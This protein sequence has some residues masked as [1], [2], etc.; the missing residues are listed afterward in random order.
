MLVLMV[1]AAVACLLSLAAGLAARR[2]LAGSLV[3]ASPVPGYPVPGRCPGQPPGLPRRWAALARAL[4]RP[5]GWVITLAGWLMLWDTVLALAAPWPLMLVVDYGLTGRPYPSWLAGAGRLSP[6]VL[7]VAAAA[8]GLA[9]LALGAVA[10][11]LVT[12]LTGVTGERVTARLRGGLIAHLLRI[13][14]GDAARYP[15]GELLNRVSADTLRVCDTVMAIADTLLPDS[16]LLAGM[17][18]ITAVLDWRLTLVVLGVVP[19]YVVLA[20]RRNRALGGAQ[21]QARQRSGELSALAADLLARIPAVHVFGRADSEATDYHRVSTGAAAAEVAA[22][23]A[24]ARFGPAADLLPGLGMAGALVAG[25]I[26]VSAGRLT[27][28]GLLVFLA[29]LSSLTSP[30]R[31][32]AQLSTTLTRGSVSRDRI[33]E[34]LAHPVLEPVAEVPSGDAGP[35]REAG[36][37]PAAVPGREPAPPLGHRAGPA[38]RLATA[39]GPAQV[40]CTERTAHRP[41][42]PGDPAG[43]RDP[44]VVRLTHPGLL[45]HAGLPARPRPAAHPDLLARHLLLARGPH[46]PGAARPALAAQTA[47]ELSIPGAADPGRPGPPPADQARPGAPAVVPGCQGAVTAAGAA[48]QLELVSFAHHPGRLVLDAASLQVRAGEFVCLAGPSGGGKSTL[49]SLLVRLAEPDCGQITIGGADISR[50]PLPRL[51]DLVT[52]VPQDPW[53]HT[54]TIAANIAYGRPGA[55]RGQVLDAARR[56][57]VAAFAAG[58]PAGY[59]TVVGE[60]GRQLSG[61]QQRRVAIARALL[62]A[63]PVLLLD[64]PTAGLDPPTEECLV[65]DLLTGRRSSTLILV[66]HQPRLQSLADRVVRLEHGRIA[67]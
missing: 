5:D 12:F 48:V 37:S 1:V 42:G 54:G 63:A 7:A 19:L 47:R 35:A 16:A 28:G 65:A 62:R 60:H 55:T 22:L 13:A 67:G 43:P 40:R 11:Y 58:L 30:V 32:L 64:E 41:A 51:R 52:L 25:A 46:A 38:I 36:V 31:A 21:R 39:R 18:V 49:L 20:R 26:E 45:A 6:A 15:A 24:S 59:D 2:R 29:Y 3:P 66:T 23:D 9:L 17:I 53:L 61:G 27:L 44:D 34:L 4:L 14:P 57:G 33:A 8:A 50:I 56:A 10:G